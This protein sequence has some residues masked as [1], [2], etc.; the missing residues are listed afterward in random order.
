[1]HRSQHNAAKPTGFQA[2]T[3]YGC[4]TRHWVEIALRL[5]TAVPQSSG[6]EML[7]LLYDLKPARLSHG[8][9]G[10]LPGGL[11]QFVDLLGLPTIRAP[12][13]TCVTGQ[14]RTWILR[15][16]PHNHRGSRAG[17]AV[18]V[19]R[20]ISPDTPH[21]SSRLCCSRPLRARLPPCPFGLAPCNPAF[22]RHYCGSGGCAPGPGLTLGP[23]ERS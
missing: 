11:N 8:R 7:L 19:T 12:R 13:D 4:T 22:R 16:A 15:G 17:P 20:T 6:C 10:R 2:A 5:P 21:R 14:M 23:T 18:S 1:V 3:G 9:R